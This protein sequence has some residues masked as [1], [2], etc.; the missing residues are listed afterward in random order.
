[1]TREDILEFIKSKGLVKRKT[2]MEKFNIS[3]QC[4]WRMLHDLFL[5]GKIERQGIGA[6]TSYKIKE[7]K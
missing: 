3:R 2:L 6:G 5:M 1:M 7:K 4:A